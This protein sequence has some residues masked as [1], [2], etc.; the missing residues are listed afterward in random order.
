L[1]DSKKVLILT[2]Y[3]PPSGGSGVQRWMY[4]AKYLKKLGWQP[5]VITVDE[6][7]AA[8]PTFDTFLLDEVK[9]INVIKTETRE[10][11]KAYS[12]L[13]TG[14][15]N[16][17]I[18]QGQVYKKGG[19][20]KFAAFI[21]GNFYIPDARKGW[22][23]FAKNEANKLI[24][25][26]SIQKVITTGP[27]HSTHLMGLELKAKLGIQWWADFR[28]PWMDIFYNQ[29]LYRTSFAKKKD[30]D[31][32]QRVLQTAD[33]ILTTVGGSLI[34]KLQ[35]KA[36]EQSFHVLPNGYDQALMSSI[37]NT[38][39]KA[40]HLV[41]TGLLTDN[42]DYLPVMGVLNDLADQYDIQ[43]S[44]AGNIAENIIKKIKTTAPKIT[45]KNKG[46]LSHKGAIA[47]MKSGDLL[48]NFI[49]TGADQDMIS[50]K[51][52]EYLAT[53]VPVLSV[54]DPQSEAG[55]FLATASFAEMIPAIQTRALKTFINKAAQQKGEAK[56]D[57]PGIKK[58]TRETISK[59]LILVLDQAKTSQ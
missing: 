57:I 5:Y 43:L 48:L 46:Y 23:S 20:A 38:S 10:P 37:P 17:G 6:K 41:Y 14:S 18:P 49:F 1:K 21:R 39:L 31:W 9:D 3:W 53:G 50:G 11:L 24:Q 59:D 25:N 55:R 27:P 22:N 32:E 12:R 28:D 13:L 47:L 26:E 42:Q 7:Q 16:K 4:F 2:Y 45:L 44:L 33:G 19:L 56:N 40:F 52:L 54:G 58:W 30:A 8:Y 29:D 51:L 15:S 36:P 35:F 34:H